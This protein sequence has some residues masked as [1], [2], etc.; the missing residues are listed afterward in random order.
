M[1]P[2]EFATQAIVRTQFEAGIPVALIVGRT[3][4]HSFKLLSEK[5]NGSSRERTNER[6]AEVHL[7]F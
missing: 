2:G 1:C 3:N 4:T 7:L 6:L 5:V